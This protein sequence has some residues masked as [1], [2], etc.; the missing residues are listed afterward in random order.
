M[1]DPTGKGRR[2]TKCSV[3]ATT[4]VAMKQVS[5]CFACWPGGPVTPPPCLK[6][7][8]HANYFAAGLCIRC[9]PWGDPGPD[10]CRDCLAWGA[11]RTHKWLCRGCIQWRIKYSNPAKGGGIGPCVGCGRTVM[12]GARGVCR[13]CHKQATFTREG[14]PF[15]AITANKH[16]QQLFLADMFTRHKT[17]TRRPGQLSQEALA[18]I[19]A[20]PR[21]RPRPAVPHW[22]TLR[23]HQLSLFTMKP[24]LAAHGRAGLHQRAHPDDVAPLEAVARDLAR[25]YRWSTKQRTAAIIGTR[26]MLGIQDDGRAPVRASEV[27]ALRDIDLPVWSV[28]KVLDTA[29]ALIEDRTPAIDAFFHQR[30]DPL[31][32]PMNEELGIWFDIMKNGTNIPPRLRARSPTTIQLHLHWA[33]PTLQAWAA[34]G[35]TSLREITRE[36]ILNA[37]PSGGLERP[38]VGQGLK[39]IFRLLKGRKVLFVDPTSRIKTGEHESRQPLPLDTGIVAERLHSENPATALIVALIAFHGLRAQ[40]VRRLLLTDIVDGRVTLNGRTIPLADPVR[41]RLTTYLNYRNTRWP[42]SINPH[43][44]IHYRTQRND[45]PVGHRW[46]LLTIGTG[47]TPKQ[48]REDRILN[49]ADATGGDIRA[50]ADLFGLSIQASTRYVSTLEAE[51]LAPSSRTPGSR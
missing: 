12:L 32:A 22:L 46:V 25:A 2:L 37:I 49:E 5:F 44:L 30:V 15:D 1:S 21:P 9:H 18:A 51:D 28:I 6:C 35:H 27:E 23:D 20:A 10:S 39:S 8:S 4:P 50:I 48:L 13:L 36:D 26:I 38:R 3:C 29:G 7:G 43:L 47:L 41:E 31:P 11:R 14:R 40:P 16:G 45:Q 42:E 34:V 24:D 19:A 33:L 17:P